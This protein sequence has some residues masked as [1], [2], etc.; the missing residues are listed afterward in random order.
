MLQI[1]NLSK[2]F[3]GKQVLRDIRFS[4][5]PGE[6]VG[7][8]GMSGSGKSTIAKCMLGLEKPTE[9]E[10]LW[11]GRSLLTWNQKSSWRQAIQIVFQDPRASL[12]PRWTIQRSL[13]EPL[14]NFNMASDKRSKWQPKELDTRVQQLLLEVGLDERFMQRYPDELS[15]GQCQ[16]VCIARALAPGPKLIVLDEPLSALD[17]TIQAQML[18]LLKELHATQQVSYLF[19][20][21]DIAVVSEL[22]E[23]VLVIDKGIIVEDNTAQGLI[24]DTKHAY[25]RKLLADTPSYPNFD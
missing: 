22:C 11:N 4:V 18:V 13:A 7:L 15:T 9:G 21:H 1:N 2:A 25:T 14:I 10:I 8:I 3:R 20:S 6:I 23:R 5:A 19:I 24:Y 17:V 12:N 16:R